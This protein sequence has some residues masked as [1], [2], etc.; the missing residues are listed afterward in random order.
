[1]VTKKLKIKNINSVFN[2]S[3][4]VLLIS[5]LTLKLDKNII[6]V[7]IIGKNAYC[8]A[9]KLKKAHVFVFFMRVSEFQLAKEVKSKTS[10]KNIV[11]NEYHGFLHVFSK[12]IPNTLPFLD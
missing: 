12:K 5:I 3:K 8:A 10:P 1:M 11:P 2:L 7:A 9:N 4:K 6:N